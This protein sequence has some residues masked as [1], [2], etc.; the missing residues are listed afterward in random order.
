MDK[1]DKKIILAGN[2]QNARK[3]ILQKSIL[4]ESFFNLELHS[5]SS[6]INKLLNNKNRIISDKESA[7]IIFNLIN[8]N[9]YNLKK[10]VFTIGASEKLLEVINDNRLANKFDFK[11]I[12]EANYKKLL[13]DYIKYLDDKNVVD[14]IYGLNLIKD[15]SLNT[16]LY[17]LNDFDLSSLEEKIFNN[18][19]NNIIYISPIKYENNIKGS[20][21][22]YG[23]YNEILN[24]LSIIKN[25]KYSIN[26]CEIIYTSDIY[27]NLIR[28]SLDANRIDYSIAN[29]HAKSTNIVTFMLDIINYI[30]NDY[31]YELLEN[32]LKNKG[33]NDIYLKEFYKTLSFT[34]YIVGFG[35]NRTIE[36]L[37]DDNRF[38]NKNNIKE[39]LNDLLS[40]GDNNNFDYQKFLDFIFKYLNNGMEIQILAN[41]LNNIKYLLA[42]SNDKILTLKDELI[43]LRY[44][45]KNENSLQ[46][47]L[48]SKTFSLKKYIF[49]IGLSQNYISGSNV[50]NPYIINLDEYINNLG[51]NKNLH[52]LAN[53]KNRNIEALDYYINYSNSYIYLSYPYF[54]KIDF[55]P[56]A[57]SV[58]YMNKGGIVFDESNGINLYDI[59]KNNTIFDNIILEAKNIEI[60]EEYDNGKI[61]ELIDE[62][63]HLDINILEHN[64]KKYYETNDYHLSPS[65]LQTLFKCP[66]EY[67]YN[68][69]LRIPEPSYPSLDE[70][71]WMDKNAK[72]TFFHEVLELYA[73]K[74]L[75]KENYLDSFNQIIFDNSFDVA[76]NNA[77]KLNP[78][79]NKDIANIDILE[80]K[81]LAIRKINEIL[82]DFKKTNYRVL[83]CEY[84]LSKTGFNHN[85][86]SF[87]GSIDRVDGKII[88]NI[89]HI[90]LID[91]K[92]GTYHKKDEN[93]Y[94]QHAIYSVCLRD[95]ANKLFGYDYDK[96]IVD[97]FIYD[98]A[99]D[100]RNNKYSNNEINIEIDKTLNLMDLLLLPYIN[101][102]KCKD[103]FEKY[104]DEKNIILNK[105]DEHTKTLCGYCSFKNI[106][107][108]RLKE[109]CEWQY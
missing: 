66:F 95:S 94:L 25:N 33:L 79:K 6:L 100:G 14:Y 106:C 83:D 56:S 69:I 78:I 93:K 34:D 36:F 108:K 104:F 42:E 46:I 1:L 90:R 75:K 43:S 51:N 89:L 38:N 54:N 81:D 74:A 8:K 49:I 64:P 32:I 98:Y 20:Y 17:I 3:F 105:S 21:P 53:L 2:I 26:E 99:F 65:S 40:F 91:Y 10:N 48:L 92:T 41:K 102:N 55:R 18:I 4:G 16:D 9:D 39:F 61:G 72:G 45:E 101:D 19:F 109:G 59:S 50:E 47:S 84:D 5:P 88:D 86:I 22:C 35:R 58:Y 85:G 28:G 30:Q 80:V 76:L 67:Y 60:K 107:Y 63:N 73:L 29:C 44:S 87:N 70:G 15:K 37:N 52:I 24:V 31:K 68:K 57:P 97:E 7:L 27:E 71:R 82:E 96:I 11:G 12:I 62:K 23:I 13:E 103:V 77:I